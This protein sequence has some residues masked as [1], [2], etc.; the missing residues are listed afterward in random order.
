VDQRPKHKT[1]YTEHDRRESG[2]GPQSHGHRGNFPEQNNSTG[3]K[4][5]KS[6][7]SKLHEVIVFNI[8][9]VLHLCKCITFSVSIFPLRDI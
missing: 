8:G 5:N 6:L 7:T 9:V 4:I 2:E 1:R 3:T